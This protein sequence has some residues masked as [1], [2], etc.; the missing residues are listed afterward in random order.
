MRQRWAAKKKGEAKG[1]KKAVGK[2]KRT[3]KAA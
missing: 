1:T 3:A 2:V